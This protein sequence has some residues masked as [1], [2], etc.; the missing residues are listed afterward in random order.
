MTRSFGGSGRE[1]RRFRREGLRLPRRSGAILMCREARLADEVPVNLCRQI[2][3]GQRKEID[4]MNAIKARLE[5]PGG[6]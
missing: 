5:R 6:L 3:E 4:Q 1:C 2:C